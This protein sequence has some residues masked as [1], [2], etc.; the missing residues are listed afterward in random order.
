MFLKIL[1]VEDFDLFRRFICSKLGSRAEFQITQASD[2]FE[3]VQKAE[4]L[5]PDLVLLDIGLPNLNGI[6]VARRMGKVAPLAKILFVSMHS[7]SEV[8]REALGLGAGYVH[9]SRVE[10]DLLPAIHAAVAGQQFVSFEPGYSSTE[11][12]LPCRHEIIF[13]SDDEILQDSLASFIA[14]ALKKGDAAIVWVTEPH[15]DNLRQRL[16]GRGVDVDAAIQGGT[17]IAAD[18]AETADPAHIAGVIIGLIQAARRAGNQNPRVAACGERAGHLWSEGR[19]DEAIRIEQLFNKLA[20]N[21][22]DLDVLCVY[23][24]PYAHGDDD[25][26]SRLCAEHC[27]MAFR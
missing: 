17:Y 23:P 8:I 21:R 9:K 3:A 13:S 19:T 10:R 16:Q 2:G 24:V 1:V 15:H 7:N 20:E 14:I 12:E 25:A 5:Q 6:E 27:A 26:F 22:D 11:W 4:E 18:A